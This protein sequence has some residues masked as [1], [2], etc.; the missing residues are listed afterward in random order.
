MNCIAWAENIKVPTPLK[1]K[2]FRDSYKS[3]TRE[4]SVETEFTEYNEALQKN[5]TTKKFAPASR[6]KSELTSE[7]L[8]THF[9]LDKNTINLHGVMADQ[10][11]ISLSFPTTELAQKFVKAVLLNPNVELH[12]QELYLEKKNIWEAGSEGSP[13]PSSRFSHYTLKPDALWIKNKA[14]GKQHHLG[15]IIGEQSLFG[16]LEETVS[17]SSNDAV[18]GTGPSSH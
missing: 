7:E 12:F 5:V 3:V 18:H 17:G 4:V 15:Q 2:L 1:A 8:S 6:T 10:L 16:T 11:P 14:T 9:F 13:F